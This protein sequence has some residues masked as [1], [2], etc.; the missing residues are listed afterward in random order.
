MIERDEVIVLPSGTEIS[1]EAALGDLS[2]AASLLSEAS[3]RGAR[4]GS[5]DREGSIA[6]LEHVGELI[7]LLASVCPSDF[8]EWFTTEKPGQL[9]LGYYDSACATESERREHGTRS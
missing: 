1:I 9:A 2:R 6:D 3:L 5:E 4:G 7:G 8:M